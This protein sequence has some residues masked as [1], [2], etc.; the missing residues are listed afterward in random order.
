MRALQRCTELD[1]E[2]DG[3]W[4]L[5]A[6]MFEK[7]GQTS[8]ANQIYDNMDPN[9]PYVKLRRNQILH[10]AALKLQRI[11]RGNQARKELLKNQVGMTPG[12]RGH[13]YYGDLPLARD[14]GRWK[15]SVRKKPLGSSF[16]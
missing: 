14:G 13:G 8:R 4:S 10:D 2:A 11:F 15:K 9:D 3:A 12:K 7:H 1:R 6:R 5:M 16:F